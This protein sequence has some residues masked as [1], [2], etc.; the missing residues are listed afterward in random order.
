MGNSQ[1]KD[2]HKLKIAEQFF[3]AF[4]TGKGWKECS[5]FV[6][7]DKATFECQG[8][9][10]IAGTKTIQAYTEWM[11]GLCKALPSSY[12]IQSVGVD[13]KRQVVTFFA[14]FN[15]THSNDVDGF[16]PATKK[17]TS[18]HY[19]Y[20]LFFDGD[21]ICKMIKVWNDGFAMKQLAWGP[22]PAKDG[23]SN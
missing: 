12:D 18:S 10:P 20:A 9:G 17:S 22:P 14:T 21:K 13:A 1:T 8:V 3:A 7:D 5:K 6:K 15:G 19:V 2:A 4:E 16:P 23:A 11:S